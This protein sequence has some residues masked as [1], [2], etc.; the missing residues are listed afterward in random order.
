MLKYLLIPLTFQSTLFLKEKKKEAAIQNKETT[1]QKLAFPLL[2]LPDTG[3]TFDFL[4]VIWFLGEGIFQVLKKH[5]S[6]RQIVCITV[7]MNKL[8]HLANLVVYLQFTLL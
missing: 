4:E 2:Q 7:R 3:T 5:S 6:G 8:V 1:K